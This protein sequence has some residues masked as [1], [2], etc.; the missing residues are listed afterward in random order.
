MVKKR[1]G[2]FLLGAIALILAV[3]AAQLLVPGEKIEQEGAGGALIVFSADRDAVFAPG[4][5]VTVRWQVDHIQ[6]V[7]LNDQAAVGQGFQVVCLDGTA[8]PTLR[9]EFTDNTSA[10]YQLPVKILI[11]QPATWLLISAAVLLGLAFLFTLLV[12][13]AP[14]EEGNNGKPRSRVITVFAGIGLLVV[15]LALTALVLELALRFYFGQY[16]TRDEK[17]AYVYSRAEIE[18]LEAQTVMLP[19]IE[20]G[21]S[22]NFP[23]HNTL[24][25]RGDEV[26]FP[27]PD[28]TFRI[29]VYGDSS[30][31]G[32]TNPYNET[33]PYY[34]G[35]VLRDEHGYENV[36]VVNAGVA[37]F[38]SWNSLVDF[39]LRGVEL[40]PDL[41]IVY[42]GG[43]DVMPREVSP[44]CYRA[45]SPFLG[46]DPRRQLRVQQGELSASVL[47][48]FVSINVG[49]A[50]NPAKSD[51][52]TVNSLIGCDMS[53]NDP[54][55]NVLANPPIYFE[56][57]VRNMIGVAQANN[58]PLLLMT[59]AYNPNSEYA[60]PYWRAA[61][62]EHNAIT[63]RLA[64]ETDTLFL[65]YATIA[66]TD[67][68]FWNDSIHMTRTGNLETAHTLANFLIDQGILPA[69]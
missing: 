47:Y 38:T 52:S 34:L 1:I 15:G 16:G 67:P 19:F 36:E 30:T 2:V 45:A 27:K 64:G 54:V 22:P 63:A 68:D 26:A 65:D 35:E 62:G 32:T 10:E 53:Q 23:G 59:Y 46:L 37:G 12:R 6:A 31:Y 7:Y 61:V 42:Q 20:Y 51:G 21:L 50:E 4:G 5:C 55:Q 49:W 43:N 40:E 3:L 69:N 24:G 60:Y 56:R 39:S 44:D 48:R 58:I 9:V 66:R 33:Y 57:N 41:V 11:Y 17:I 14:A 25:Y 28:G 8:L 13:P 18:A 29:V